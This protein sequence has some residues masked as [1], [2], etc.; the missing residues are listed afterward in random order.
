M[1]MF[2][3]VYLDKEY[4]CP[5][6]QRKVDSIQVKEFE[7]LLEN[8]H[9]KDCI[10]HELQHRYIE[11]KGERDLYERFTTYKKMSRVLDEL[12]QEGH[13]ILRQAAIKAR[14]TKM[15]MKN[16]LLQDPSIAGKFQEQELEGLL[17]PTNYI[18][19]AIVQ[20]EHALSTL[21]KQHFA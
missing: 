19:L 20:I 4:A 17:D 16:I 5:I 12:W 10:S 3:T 18:G 1:G 15:P 2:D 7:N 6:C 11:E 14:K 21:K 8:Y 13:E 9:V